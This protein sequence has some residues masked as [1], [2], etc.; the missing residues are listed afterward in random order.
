MIVGGAFVLYH[1][2]SGP[3]AKVRIFVAKSALVGTS[4]SYQARPP[5]GMKLVIPP[6]ILA[7]TGLVWAKTI[8]N[9]QLS[10]TVWF[11]APTRSS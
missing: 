5:G 11:V 2:F 3:V 6:P 4:T 10:S 7:G 8:C 9:C 1:M